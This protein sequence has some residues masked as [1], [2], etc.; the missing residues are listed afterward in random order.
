MDCM[1]LQ[2]EL[3]DLGVGSNAMTKLYRKELS[4]NVSYPPGYLYED[5]GTTYKLIWRASRI[6]YLN[7]VLYYHCYREGSITTLKTEKSLYD[8][9][10]MR[11]Q[12]YHDLSA[13]GYPAD[14][15]EKLLKKLL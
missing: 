10:D 7:N 13:W 6:Y 2:M 15:L 9:I 12:Q 1:N 11:L 5:V 14:K 8:W 3:L 4:D